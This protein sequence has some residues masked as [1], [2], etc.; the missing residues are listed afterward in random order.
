MTVEAVTRKAGP[1]ACEAG[2]DYPF[3]FKVFSAS[4][5]YVVLAENGIET[6]AGLG[7]DYV[8]RL[9]AN[10]DNE[11]GGAV[12]LLCEAAGKTVTIGSCVPYTQE[13]VITN[14]GGFYPAILNKA[15]DKLTILVQQLLEEVSRCV[16]VT[17]SGQ[18]K[19][20][21][22]IQTLYESAQAAKESAQLS[23]DKAED[24]AASAWAAAESAGE[25][26]GSAASAEGSAEEAYAW[27]NTAEDALY[28][29]DAHVGYSAYHYAQKAKAN[30][31]A[32]A[33]A[34]M[35]GSL[36]GQL[37]Y[38][39]IVLSAL[40][41]DS[42][43]LCLLDGQQLEKG[44]RY[45]K[46]ISHIAGLQEDYPGL[47]VTETAWWA[48]VWEHGSCGKF[49]LGEDKIRLPKVSDILQCTTDA[50][51]VGD[52]VNAGLPNITGGAMADITNGAG[53]FTIVGGAFYREAG[54]PGYA[55][56]ADPGYGGERFR[57]LKLDASRSSTIYGAS[58]TVQPQT[59]KVLAYIVVDAVDVNALNALLKTV[60][61]KGQPGQV[62]VKG[63]DGL[64]WA[65]RGNYQNYVKLNG[66]V[67]L[68]S[69]DAGK[70][71]KIPDTEGELPAIVTLPPI[72]SVRKG[73]R[74]I[75]FTSSLA[76]SG[77]KVFPSEGDAILH[78]GAMVS[79]IQGNELS[80]LELVA[81]GDYWVMLPKSTRMTHLNQFI[82]HFPNGFILQSGFAT[83]P[84]N[85]T[86]TITFSIPFPHA[87]VAT[88]VSKASFPSNS[89]SVAAALQTAT[90]TQINNSGESSYACW[91]AIGY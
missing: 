87:C 77:C 75:F 54:V 39:Q 76:I 90:G 7:T 49:V 48:A 4:D 53:L 78:R 89:S 30:A 81:A 24:A 3:F 72:Q 23:V 17:I 18:E 2:V 69:S 13:V 50:N 38:G 79:E 59:L 47:F 44:G 34:I 71:F 36:V 55:V 19:P 20:D 12:T 67:T 33:S 68:T 42:D 32:A 16:K 29:T 22:L 60:N 31:D 56:R 51:A 8:V 65:G 80:Y 11:P 43:G 35:P 45:D 63:E 73:A 15:Y 1:Y 41:I 64:E 61:E 37:F 57:T 70:V 5:V 52:I 14:K 86:V 27:A 46:F 85:S 40:P 84:A 28:Q 82:M 26:A 62:L 83:C 88:Y 10:Q 74:F 21:T 91:M 25:A 58:D 66:E 6:L 9:N